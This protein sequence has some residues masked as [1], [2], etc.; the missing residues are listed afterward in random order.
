MD[1][2]STVPQAIEEEATV[3]VPSLTMAELVTQPRRYVNP[4]DCDAT[5]G[6]DDRAGKWGRSW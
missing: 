5:N 1:T 6:V 2:T 4:A 3:P